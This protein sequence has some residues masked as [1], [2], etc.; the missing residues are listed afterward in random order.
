MLLAIN[1]TRPLRPVPLDR[2]KWRFAFEILKIL[3]WL[4]VVGT[5]VLV[6]IG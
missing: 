6:A 3:V 1:P 2:S 4:A 5:A